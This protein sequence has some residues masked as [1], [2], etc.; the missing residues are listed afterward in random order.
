VDTAIGTT[1]VANTIL[2]KG[3]AVEF[4][5]SVLLSKCTI[6][7]KF[8]A[9]ISWVP[10][11]NRSSCHRAEFQIIWFLGPLNIENGIGTC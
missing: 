5:L 7:E 3:S 11:L 2:I 1:R 9:R 8:L 10:E 6:F 4:G